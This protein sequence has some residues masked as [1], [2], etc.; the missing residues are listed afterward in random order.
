MKGMITSS[1]CAI[2]K[3]AAID[4]LVVGP[5]R[6]ERRRICASYTII[7]GS[8]K[9]T[10]SLIY[11]FQENVFEPERADYQN[12]ADVMAAQVALNY[13]LF[14]REIEFQGSLDHH[15]RRFIAAMA[16]NTAREIFVNRI[17]KPNPFLS[18]D[19]AGIPA[20]RLPRYLQA[21]ITFTH[22]PLEQRVSG[23]GWE[24]SSKKYA[25]LSSGGKDSLLSF[26]LLQETEQDVHPLFVNESGRHWL[27]ALNAYR[28]IGSTSPNAAKVWTNADRL[29]SWAVRHLP[30]IRKDFSRV[31]ADIYPVRL[32]TV[33]VFIFGVIPLMKKRGLGKLV[34]GDEYDTTRRRRHRGIPHYDGLYDQSIY[35][36]SSMTTYFRKKG[37][38][39]HQLSLLRPLS[40]MLIEKIL[41]ERYPHL[42]KHQMSCHAAHTERGAVKPCGKCEKCRRIVGMLT[43]IGKDPVWCGYEPAQTEAC[44]R[45]IAEGTSKQDGPDVQ[46]LLHLLKQKG[47]IGAQLPDWQRPMERR[48]IMMVRLDAERSPAE[49]LPPEIRERLFGIFLEHADGA[50]RRSDRCWHNIDLFEEQESGSQKTRKQKRTR[51]QKGGA[52]ALG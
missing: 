17:L 8:K 12:L 30:F 35:F 29:F 3:L 21:E 28:F 45:E 24:T 26:G 43:A 44:L 49:A 18:G 7:Q 37:W 20:H 16:E 40:E 9:D 34:I 1:K 23:K 33:A 50:V 51:T 31:R 22:K 19:A 5:A 52:E 27:T 42:Q 6:I 46:H 39:I 32:W 14:C 47:S 4:K 10:A 38:G 11:S 36:D 13:G 48:E 15:D 2:E 25:V 41:S